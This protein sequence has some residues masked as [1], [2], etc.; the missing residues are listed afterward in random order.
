MKMVKSQLWCA[1]L[2]V[3][4]CAHEPPPQKPYVPVQP[5][6]EPQ[7][8]TSAHV[9]HWSTEWTPVFDG[10]DLANWVATDFAGH[11]EITVSSNQINIPAGAELSGITW[12]NGTLP[13]TNYEISLEAMKIDGSDFFC[14]LTFP[15]ADSHC[16]LIL[17]GWGGAVVGLSSL[18]DNDA[19][20][21]ETSRTMPFVNNHWYHVVVRVKPKQ[22][23]AWLDDKKIVDVSTVDRKV[24]LRAGPIFLSAPLGVATYETS[25]AV[26]DIKIRLLEP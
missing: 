3:C 1:F 22:I 23:Q 26:R 14:G 18:D 17:G 5:R 13:K 25:A 9:N 6:P 12:T 8:K 24:D 11:G 2:L 4:S 21:N 16:S 15:V 20:E 10:K 19:S 7:P